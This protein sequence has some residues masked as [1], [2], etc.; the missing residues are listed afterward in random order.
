MSEYRRSTKTAVRDPEALRGR[1]TTAMDSQIAHETD[2]IAE[3]L[4]AIANKGDKVV[5]TSGQRMSHGDSI[6]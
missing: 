3:R 5:I 1:I 4:F 6:I 2:E